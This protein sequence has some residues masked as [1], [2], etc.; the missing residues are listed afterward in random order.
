MKANSYRLGCPVW[1]CPDWRGALYPG[2]AKPADFLTHYASVFQCVEGNSTFYALPSADT[3]DRWRDATPDGFHFC[4]K[5][6]RTISHDRKL[7]DAERE[8]ETF[9][10]LMARLPDR[11]GPLLLQLPPRFGP[12]QLPDLDAYL[13][14][15]PTTF[16]YAVEVRHLDLF[17]SHEADLSAILTRHG[18]SRGLMDT[19]ALHASPPR[20][21]TTIETQSRKP[22][23]PW[24][25]TTHA[26]RPFL[27]FVG[28]ND[29]KATSGYLDQW[30]KWLPDGLQRACRRTCSCMRRTTNLRLDSRAPFTTCSNGGVL[31]WATI[32]YGQG[33]DPAANS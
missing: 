26:G 6:P 25:T 9:L 14:K 22:K 32:R 33:N 5:F 3:V 10:A 18:A 24:C 8:T 21:A 17:G 23:V 28:Q 4:F 30:R 27:R 1:A 12:A 20:D 19:R 15:L 29:V 16:T 13:A 2:G 11:L 7:R 31:H